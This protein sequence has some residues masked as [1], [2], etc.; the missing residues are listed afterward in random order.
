MM[1]CRWLAYVPPAV[2][3]H[4]GT[5][6]CLLT[7]F[8]NLLNGLVP[9]VCVVV[10]SMKA[11]HGSGVKRLCTLFQEP[12]GPYGFRMLIACPSGLSSMG[13]TVSGWPQPNQAV[14]SLVV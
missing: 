4:C 13:V 11:T 12:Y 2:C 1:V 5:A 6:S 8:V 14:S 10:L 3:V 7:D 9:G